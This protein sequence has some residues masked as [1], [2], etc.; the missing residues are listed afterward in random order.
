M[1]CD[2]TVATTSSMI[3]SRCLGMNA[4]WWRRSL[5]C[6]ALM[7]RGS[8]VAISEMLK[9]HRVVTMI[10][11]KLAGDQG[12]VRGPR[13]AHATAKP[14]RP[15]RQLAWR[16]GVSHEIAVCATRTT[17]TMRSRDAASDPTS[18]MAG[19][20]DA[21]GSKA[22]AS[23]GRRCMPADLASGLLDDAGCVPAD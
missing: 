19:H 1:C 2:S 21:A 3:G 18:S 14:T 9:H 5:R 15:G 16:S 10:S 17:S 6:T 22:S 20:T 7:R 23:S 11:L 13:P 12:L 8:G 4:P